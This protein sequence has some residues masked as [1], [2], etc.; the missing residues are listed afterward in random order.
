MERP[1]SAD[2]DAL[3]DVCAPAG[4]VDDQVHA[5]AGGP[6]LLS[7]ISGGIA[8]DRFN[9]HHGAPIVARGLDPRVVQTLLGHSDIEMT[10]LYLNDRGLSRNEWKRVAVATDREETVHGTDR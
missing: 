3:P 7:R 9:G 1:P 8:Q 5:G 6:Q 10:Q 2:V 4:G